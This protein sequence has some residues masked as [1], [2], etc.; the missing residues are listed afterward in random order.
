M[1]QKD[2]KQPRNTSL[3]T[4]EFCAGKALVFF[5]QTGEEA[6]FIQRKLF[7]MGYKWSGG[8]EIVKLVDECVG[9]GMVLALWGGG[10]RLMHGARNER[11]LLCTVDQFDEPFDRNDPRNAPS[12]RE[13]MMILFNKLSTRLAALEETQREIL[14]E[15]RHP[16]PIDLGKSRRDMQPGS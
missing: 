16:A 12:E 9:G 15:L 6:V 10:A 7:E 3:L 2:E 1:G 14:Q 4:R 8:G 11:G 5:P 13:M